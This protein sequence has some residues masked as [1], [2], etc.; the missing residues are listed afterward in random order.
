MEK[1]IQ[2][3]LPGMEEHATRISAYSWEMRTAIN[4]LSYEE[5]LEL[6]DQLHDKHA[7]GEITEEAFDDGIMVMLPEINFSDL[8]Q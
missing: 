8:N 7:R 2:N 6:V 4:E 1:G 5:R 3:T